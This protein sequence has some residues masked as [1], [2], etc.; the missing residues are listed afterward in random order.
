MCTLR[1][2]NISFIYN[3]IPILQNISFNFKVGKI[4]TL[5]GKSGSGKTS[6]LKTL[7]GLTTFNGNIYLNEKNIYNL[8]PQ[9]LH[10][11]IQYLHQ[12]PVLFDGSVF[13]NLLLPSYLKFNS[14]LKIDREEILLLM[15]KLGL[16]KSYL[17]K[18]AQKLSGGE[19]QRI[20]II[21]AIL[22]KP[23][24]LLLDEPTSALDIKNEE[25]LLTLVKELKA[26]MCIILAT[27]SLALIKNSDSI[28]YIDN[29]RIIK[30]FDSLNINEIKQLLGS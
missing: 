24:F 26:K 16:D 18:D 29:G 4:Y 25:R 22:L 30:T 23:I 9:K 19:K 13:C 5:F 28:I 27:H 1:L 3:D 14:M 2:D 17:E 12:E 21:R 15:K 6:L 20:A 11:N 7:C 10:K 8:N